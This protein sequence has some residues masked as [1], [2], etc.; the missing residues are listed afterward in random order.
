MV[1][2]GS[3][4]ILRFVGQRSRSQLLKIEQKC[5]SF[6][7]PHNI[8]STRNYVHT[9]LMLRGT[10]L[11]NLRFVGQRSRSQFLKFSNLILFNQNIVRRFLTKVGTKIDSYKMDVY[12]TSGI[13]NLAVIFKMATKM[14]KN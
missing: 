4:L 5:D 3:L 2:G 6:L 14:L 12:G 11:V 13:S 7:F 9:I 8:S 10:S 1:R